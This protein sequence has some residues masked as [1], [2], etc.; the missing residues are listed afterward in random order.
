MLLEKR[1]LIA[2][3]LIIA[4]TIN[5][6]GMISVAATGKTI[7]EKGAVESKGQKVNYYEEYKESFHYLSAMDNDNASSGGTD[8][9]NFGV[10]NDSVQGEQITLNDEP[11]NLSNNI[12]NLPEDDNE[13]QAQNNYEEEPEE[14]NQPTEEE[15]TTINEE[16]TTTE[17]EETT[18][19][20]EPTTIAPTTTE[21]ETT[22]TVEETT[23]TV[24][25]T[26]TVVPTTTMREPST[27]EKATES[28]TVVEEEVTNKEATESEIIKI[29]ED[30]TTIS[31]ADNIQEYIISTENETNKEE[32]I[33]NITTYSDIDKTIVVATYTVSKWKIKKV[34][35]PKDSEG[36]SKHGETDED[37]INTYYLEVERE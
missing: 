31:E 20:E 1:R 7:V 37:R 3:M 16:P 25:E 26:T 35:L 21:E 17:E 5:G 32:K 24:E 28:E 18:T 6:Q 34:L 36:Y 4:M 11:E 29:E 27:E 15:E 12:N 2:I 33:E 19:V 13:E 14:N 8:E 9:A 10:D 23:T 30:I 22:T